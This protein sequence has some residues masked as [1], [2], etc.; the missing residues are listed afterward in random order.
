MN[1]EH[2]KLERNPDSLKSGII[3]GSMA[4]RIA[5]VWPLTHE[6]A[7]ISKKH[8]AERRL[9]RHVTRVIRRKH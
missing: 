8:D 4:E 3:P 7:S 9:Q 6:V 5:L 2:T 1:R